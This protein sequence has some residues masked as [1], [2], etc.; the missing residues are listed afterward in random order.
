MKIVVLMVSTWLYIDYLVYMSRDKLV[1]TLCLS[2][3]SFGCMQFDPS[4]QLSSSNLDHFFSCVHPAFHFT[5]LSL[6][7]CSRSTL[8]VVLGLGQ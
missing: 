3:S 5:Q 1:N 6:S 7:C 8:I 2:A 4:T